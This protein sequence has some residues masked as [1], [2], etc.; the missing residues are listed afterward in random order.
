MSQPLVISVPHSLGKE[1][2]LRRLAPGLT[3]LTGDMPML[4]VENESWEGDQLS[5]RV[6]AL[7]QLASGTLLAAEDHVRISIMLPWLLRQAAGGLETAIRARGKLL[8]EDKSRPA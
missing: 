6:R 3:A 2:V 4:V 1:E 5:F 8:L 7:G